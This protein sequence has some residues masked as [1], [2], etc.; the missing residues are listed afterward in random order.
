ML[1][2]LDA[3]V[4]NVPWRSIIYGAAFGA[5]V[6]IVLNRLAYVDG[7][8]KGYKAAAF[9][10]AVRDHAAR[11]GSAPRSKTTFHRLVR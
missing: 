8:R 2:W 11:Q 6:A 9:D 7:Y 3:I 1:E 4:L 5:V 10:A